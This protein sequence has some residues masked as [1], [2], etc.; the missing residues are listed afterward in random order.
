M[1]GQ[2]RIGDVGIGVCPAH[3]G[4]VEYVTT[5]ITGSISAQT[6]GKPSAI[7]TTVGIS[8]CG[9]PT[10]AI[11]GSTTVFHEGKP[12]HRIG[13]AGINPGAYTAV[14]GSTNVFAG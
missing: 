6:N 10:V 9:H 4:S 5:F 11:S 8:T 1:S 14:S 7:I 2:S 12:A 13:D 3:D